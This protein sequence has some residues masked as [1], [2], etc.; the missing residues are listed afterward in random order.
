MAMVRA[1]AADGSRGGMWPWL[2]QRVT[3]VL[4]LVTI[5]VHLVLTHYV[6]IG[7]LSFEN[8]GDRLGA[9]AVLVN[10]VVLELVLQNV[11]IYRFARHPQFKMRQPIRFVMFQNLEQPIDIGFAGVGC[12]LPSPR[13]KRGGSRNERGKGAPF[14]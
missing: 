7:Q 2:G 5:S 4:V 9:G 10:D 6:A 3:A 13:N 1:R 8:I 14:L 12:Q 11:F